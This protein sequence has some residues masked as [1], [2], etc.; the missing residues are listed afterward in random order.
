VSGEEPEVEAAAAD[1]RAVRNP[2]VNV[3]GQNPAPASTTG[4]TV[5]GT[6]GAA[7]GV[8]GTTQ[9]PTG[10]SATWESGTGTAAPT[11]ASL[12]PTG[13]VANAGDFSLTATGTGFLPTSVMLFDGVNQ[14]TTYISATQVR[15]TIPNTSGRN[16]GAKP[17]IVMNGPVATAAVNCTLT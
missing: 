1:P 17:V 9:N 3:T 15:A 8:S 14:D 16:A 10:G 11:L 7:A 4:T 12:S 2:P 6:S 5:S 13:A